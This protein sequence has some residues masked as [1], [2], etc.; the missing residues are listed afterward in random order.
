MKEPLIRPFRAKKT[1]NKKSGQN[2]WEQDLVDDALSVIEASSARKIV[3]VALAH[4]GWVAIEL[5]YRLS[6][7]IPKIIH[8][9]WIIGPAPLPFLRALE[10]MHSP[11][12]SRAALKSLF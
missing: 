4:S 11:E 5:K 6:S 12:H 10:A 8:M 9:E 3:P 1:N 7:R 2:F